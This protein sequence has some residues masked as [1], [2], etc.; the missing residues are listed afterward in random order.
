MCGNADGS[1]ILP[2][3]VIRKSK[4]P[5]AFKGKTGTQLGFHYRNNA[6]ARMTS[7]FF[8]EWLTEWDLKLRNANQNVLLWV[9][10][11][12]GH[13]APATITNI[14]M[15]PFLPN[16]TSHVQPMDAGIIRCFKAQY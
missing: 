13:T 3:F 12:T 1:D 4:K 7:I 6:K 10:N 11:F 15:E 14:W 5:R 16:L 2:P 9:N 8:E